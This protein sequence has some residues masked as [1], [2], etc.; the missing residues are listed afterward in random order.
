MSDAR[1][2][3]TVVAG[4]AI[5][6]LAGCAEVYRNHGYVPTDEDLALVD[7]GDTQEAVAQAVGRPTA[8]GIL[9]DTGWYYVKSRYRNF[10]YRAPEEV[11]REVVAISFTDAGEVSNIERYGLEDGNVVVLSRRVTDR[12]TEGVGFLRQLLGNIGRIDP[13]QLLDEE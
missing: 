7:L 2:V 9:Q 3:M 8:T 13:A 5:A 12:N 11:D 6:V 4:L 1:K 10:A